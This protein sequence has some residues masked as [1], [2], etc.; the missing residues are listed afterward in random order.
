MSVENTK[1]QVGDVLRLIA[2]NSVI[3]KI[4]RV[5]FLKNG[6]SCNSCFYTDSDG[7]EGEFGNLTIG[8]MPDGWGRS[9]ELV[10][11]ENDN[12]SKP[13]A[14]TA[15]SLS[16]NAN[17]YLCGCGRRCNSIGEKKCWFCDRPIVT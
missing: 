15:A 4:T 3:Y 7:M 13:E 8:G 17:D 16:V 6:G 2:N 14:Q 11:S 5:E 1:L 10:S 9:W 12:A